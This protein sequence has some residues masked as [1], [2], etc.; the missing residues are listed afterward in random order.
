MLEIIEH[1]KENSHLGLM[2]LGTDL[3]CFRGKTN[4]TGLSVRSFLNFPFSDFYIGIL[5]FKP[6]FESVTSSLPV[7]H[8]W[9]HCNTLNAPQNVPEWGW[10]NTRYKDH[11]QIAPFRGFN[12]VL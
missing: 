4:L 1:G 8:T 11:I 7:T 10:S 3:E 5:S 2:K 6:T 9:D 12:A